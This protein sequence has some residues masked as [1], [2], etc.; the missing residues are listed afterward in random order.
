M[1]F[2]I[3]FAFFLIIHQRTGAKG[4]N[5]T[6]QRMANPWFIVIG[7]ANFAGGFPAFCNAG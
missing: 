7:I 3:H 4:S 1:I 2:R 5:S 6:K